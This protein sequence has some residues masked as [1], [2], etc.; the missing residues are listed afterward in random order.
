MT[1]PTW[2]TGPNP[3]ARA[4]VDGRPVVVAQRL[5]MAAW[6][7]AAD[8]ATAMRPTEL[9]EWAAANPRPRLADAMRALAAPPN[10]ANVAPWELP[11]PAAWH[12]PANPWEVAS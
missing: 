9:A 1:A 3:A 2:P 7:R 10:P 5:A 12:G 4:H 11:T 6:E 8:D